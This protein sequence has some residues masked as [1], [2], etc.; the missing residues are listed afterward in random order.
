M[1]RVLLVQ[2]EKV[3][4]E[5]WQGAVYLPTTWPHSGFSLLWTE[6][7]RGD[8]DTLLGTAWPS[9]RDI[10]RPVGIGSGQHLGTEV[11][12]EHPPPWQYTHLC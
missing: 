7:Y 12:H 9:E 1:E 5:R 2:G 11:P 3:T 10:W 8:P 6:H 4:G